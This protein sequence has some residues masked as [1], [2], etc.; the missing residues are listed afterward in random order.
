MRYWILALALGLCAFAPIYTTHETQDKVDNEITNLYTQA[1]S[2]QFRVYVGTPN[3]SE[4]KDGEVII[5]SAGLV[6]LMFRQGQEIYTV[7]FSCIT[8]R[9]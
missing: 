8:V 9:R 5:S 6:R 2:N 4:M 3:L 7:N 1:Q